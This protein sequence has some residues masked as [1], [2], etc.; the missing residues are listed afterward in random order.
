MSHP[1]FD[2]P[3]ALSAAYSQAVVNN[4]Y[5]KGA[6]RCSGDLMFRSQ[7]ARDLACIVDVDEKVVAWMCL[8]GEIRTSEGSHVPDLMVDYGNGRR[9]F[10]DSSEDEGDVSITE[11]A[12]CG[13]LH[14]RFVSR[15]EIEG[16]YRL[17]N[18]RDILRYANYRTPLN[19]RVR[20]LAVLDEAGS[21]TIAECLSVFREVQP[22]TGVAWMILH[23]LIETDL[24]T[25]ML[26]PESVLRR[27][28]R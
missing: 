16:G 2:V 28:H 23:R 8:P 14:H 20:L 19:D 1:H 5:P 18:A 13:Q 21:L 24:D 22:M 7:L 10:L 3:K 25:R 9:I 15:A 12:A 26:G 4:F 17:A 6:V 11:A 27:F